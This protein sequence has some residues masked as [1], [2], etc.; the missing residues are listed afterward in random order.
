M[1]YGGGQ[2]LIPACKQPILPLRGGRQA[3]ALR[4]AANHAGLLAARDDFDFL[5]HIA[6]CLPFLVIFNYFL[7]E[8]H[9][10]SLMALIQ[11]A[12]ESST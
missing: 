11:T 2:G 4:P 3:Q 1:L 8:A 9:H 6:V 12:N 7:A 10:T 5:F